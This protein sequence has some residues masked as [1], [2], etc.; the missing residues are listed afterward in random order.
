M[1][2]LQ[3]WR[4]K[5]ARVNPRAISRLRGEMQSRFSGGNCFVVGSAPRVELVPHDHSICVNASG[6][7]AAK[8]GIACP[9]LTLLSAFTLSGKSDV[10]NSSVQAMSGLR[11]KTLLLVD[12]KLSVPEC[13]AVLR[14]TGY[15]FDNLLCVSVPD[16]AEIF[17]EICGE[18]VPE[19]G[20]DYRPSSG[21][22]AVALA[23]LGD[24]R[25]VSMSGFSFEG[26]HAY[27]TGHTDRAHVHGDKWFLARTTDRAIS[28]V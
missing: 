20:T 9:D 13:K 3:R 25:S 18:P 2:V 24:A 8:L 14:D 21:L 22:F 12:S 10:H 16:R 5:L 23:L 28:I 17:K 27:M 1:S 15:I 11:T 4:R 19:G 7:S 6:W 26:G